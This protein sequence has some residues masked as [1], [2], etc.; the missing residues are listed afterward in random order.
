MGGSGSG[1]QGGRPTIGRTRAYAL[2][3]RSLRDVLRHGR[4][5]FRM[6]FSSDWDEVVVAGMV[7]TSEPSPRLV[8]AH[9]TRREPQE[10]LT[11]EIALVRTHPH[12]GGV[13]W[14]FLC[15][16]TGR[17]VAKLYLPIGG[18]HF[19][20][21]QAYGLVHDTRQMS[22]VC[23]LSKRVSRIAGQL[24]APD[25]DFLE[26]PE[27]PIRMRWRTYDQ[28]VSRWYRARDAYWSVLDRR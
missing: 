21:R 4:C 16:R 5:G 9:S 28:F 22:M 3:T 23:L 25:C 14:W 1:R 24:G 12:L 2:S 6:T 10:S 19:L 26:P 27:K 11:C 8:I 17:R 20:S 7:E 18:R 15:P 13:R